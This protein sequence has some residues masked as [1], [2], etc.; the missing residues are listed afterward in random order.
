MKAYTKNQYL[1]KM[2]EGRNKRDRGDAGGSDKK[3]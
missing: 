1:R 3:W 2:L